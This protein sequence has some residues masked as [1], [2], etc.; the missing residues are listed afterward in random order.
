MTA[1]DLGDGINLDHWVFDRDAIPVAATVALTV[2]RPDASTVTPVVT[3]V[4]TGHYR[5]ATFTANQV[6]TWS[7]AWTVSGAV[8]DV[9]PGYFVV[10][11]PGYPQ[12]YASLAQM[13]TFLKRDPEDTRDDEL[14]QAAL[15]SVTAEIDNVCER[16]FNRDLV[17]TARTFPVCLGALRVDDFYSTAG[18]I[19]GGTAYS[20][21]TWTLRPRNGVLNGRRGWAYTSI[22]PAY[23]ITSSLTVGADVTIT[24][25]WGWADVPAPVHEA[26]KIAT[27]DT[28]GLKD[29]RFGVAGYGEFG[30]IRVRDNAMVMRKLQPYLRNLWAA[31]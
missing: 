3:A 4:A 9:E 6:G 2:T 11:D 13:K 5:A 24:A 27:A 25:L 17:A 8:V 21:T 23:G 18:L 22:V 16:T 15:E 28:L 19:I 14:I 30:P 10:A 26:C 20:S 7:Y 12:P 31:A 29:A 1:Y